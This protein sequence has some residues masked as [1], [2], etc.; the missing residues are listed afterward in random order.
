VTDHN[1][2]SSLRIPLSVVLALALPPLGPLAWIALSGSRRSDYLR[3]A[4]VRAG[5]YTG[6]VSALPLLVVGVAAWLGLWPDPNPNPI[7]LGL[8]LFA[9]G[10]LATI[11]IAV[12]IVRAG[13]PQR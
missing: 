1:P 13:Q 11:L 12:G 9:G 10:T 4:W 8:L 2:P 7:G 6:G 5:F 3:S